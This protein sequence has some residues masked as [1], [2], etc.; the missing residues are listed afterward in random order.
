MS[1]VKRT[2]MIDKDLD[3]KLTMEVT[4]MSKVVRVTK[5]EIVEALIRKWL[6]REVTL[7]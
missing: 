4:R 2:F 6:K 7:G 1:K 3:Y 5:S